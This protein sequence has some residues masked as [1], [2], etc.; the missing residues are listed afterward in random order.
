MDRDAEPFPSNPDPEWET[1][2][3]VGTEAVGML[4]ILQSSKHSWSLMVTVQSLS[5]G[6]LWD[7]RSVVSDLQNLQEE[8]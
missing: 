5:T 7:K 3:F 1:W 8:V 4:S 2:G 6:V